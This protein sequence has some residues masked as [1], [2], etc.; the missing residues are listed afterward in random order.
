MGPLSGNQAHCFDGFAA[1]T[2][3]LQLMGAGA[4]FADSGC[5]VMNAE[6]TDRSLPG[7][8][9]RGWMGS[10]LALLC[11]RQCSVFRPF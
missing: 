6:E 10:D 5:I 2:E 11:G 8:Q 1:L 3:P 7:E 9:A 4:A